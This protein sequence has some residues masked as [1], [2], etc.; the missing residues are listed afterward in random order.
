VGFESRLPGGIAE[1][2]Y[3]YKIIEVLFRMSQPQT[4]ADSKL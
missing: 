2:K 3:D 1:K 4:K